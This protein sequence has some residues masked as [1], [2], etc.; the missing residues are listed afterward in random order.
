MRLQSSQAN[1][2]AAAVLNAACA[3]GRTNVSLEECERV[4]KTSASEGTSIRN[5]ISGAK[6]TGLS[7]ACEIKEAKE[8]VALLLL[9]HWVTVGGAVCVT[10][11]EDSHW[12]TVIGR[13]GARYLVADSADSELVLSLSSKELLERWDS[14]IGRTRFY[15]AVFQ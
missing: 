4:C 12:A 8:Y 13:V 14:G 10:V 6:T 5:L 3:L 1:C 2:G 9:A 15:G 11:D 7:L